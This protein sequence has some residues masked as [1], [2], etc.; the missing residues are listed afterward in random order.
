[1]ITAGKRFPNVQGEVTNLALLNRFC[2]L[3]NFYE[4]H[5]LLHTP[6][7]NQAIDIAVAVLRLVCR[8]IA[9]ANPPYS[10]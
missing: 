10:F 4:P 6:N 7:F 5:Q 3:S 8:W 1:M 2:S 9:K